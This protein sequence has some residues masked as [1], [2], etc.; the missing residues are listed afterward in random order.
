MFHSLC[1]THTCTHTQARANKKV[2]PGPAANALATL[3]QSVRA[4]GMDLTMSKEVD[5]LM[6]MSSPVRG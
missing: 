3:N 2:E 4:A 5:D 6:S 1:L